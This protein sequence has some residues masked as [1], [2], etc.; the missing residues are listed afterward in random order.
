MAMPEAPVDKDACVVLP[1][2]NVRMAGKLS[3]IKPV[4][5]TAAPQIMPHDDFRFRVSRPDCGHVP[6]PLLSRQDIH[7]QTAV[8][9]NRPSGCASAPLYF[10]SCV[11]L[12]VCS[13]NAQAASDNNTTGDRT[14]SAGNHALPGGF[15][16]DMP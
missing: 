11:T 3:R 16:D 1:Q 8:L 13:G 10:H 12:L 2:D 5:E 7:L 9:N 4:T 14:K 15:S 6:V